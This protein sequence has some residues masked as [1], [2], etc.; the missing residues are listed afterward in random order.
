MR[1]RKKKAKKE[2]HTKLL[3]D[4][5]LMITKGFESALIYSFTQSIKRMRKQNKRLRK[6]QREYYIKIIKLLKGE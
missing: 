1:K 2:A 4:C 5:M 6:L 3:A